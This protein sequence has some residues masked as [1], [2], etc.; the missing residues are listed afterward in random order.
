[1]SPDTTKPMDPGSAGQYRAEARAARVALGFATDSIEVAPTDI[2]AAIA[3]LK[4]QVTTLTEAAEEDAE[5][6][7]A[8]VKA[9]CDH[10]GL[11]PDPEGYT[12]ADLESLLEEH[13]DEIDRVY[14]ESKASKTLATDLASEMVRVHRHMGDL[15]AATDP[16]AD[17]F[18]SHHCVGLL[19]ARARSAGLLPAS[20]D[21]PPLPEP[22]TFTYANWR[23]ETAVR[24]ARPV[25]VYYGSTEWHSEPQWLM[26][27]YDADKG[28]LRTFAMRDM[29]ASAV[30]PVAEIS[31]SMCVAAS[32]AAASIGVNLPASQAAAVICA[33]LTEVIRDAEIAWK[34]IAEAKPGSGGLVL[35][36]PDGVYVSG[37][38]PD[39]WVRGFLREDGTTWD[40]EGFP[41]KAGHF[42]VPPLLPASRALAPD[43]LMERPRD[44]PA[45]H[46]GEQFGQIVGVDQSHPD[47]RGVVDEGGVPGLHVEDRPTS[48]FGVGANVVLGHDGKVDRSQTGD[49]GA[50]EVAP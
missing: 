20:M 18:A 25:R 43:F 48:S 45:F 30:T 9:I 5:F 50:N 49:H 33:A 7:S 1:M 38:M 41:L 12:T 34:P 46:E 32:D 21:R 23:G 6:V 19:L 26:E 8:I 17:A 36:N 29:S 39:K 31:P 35:G 27:A 2:T 15:L 44:P 22:L 11:D 28:L 47:L 10:V 42:L 4:A 40:D 37:S 24:R 13:N 3:S 14:A 16:G